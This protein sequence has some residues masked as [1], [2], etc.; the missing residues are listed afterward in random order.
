MVDLN[1]VKHLAREMKEMNRGKP[2]IFP[3]MSTARCTGDSPVFRKMFD[4]LRKMLEK[5]RVKITI[6]GDAA[7][8]ARKRAQATPQVACGI[9]ILIYEEKFRRKARISQN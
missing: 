6:M 2:R 4:R 5:M 3:L 9:H 7:Y 8:D 1:F